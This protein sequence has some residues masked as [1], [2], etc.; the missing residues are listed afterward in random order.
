MKKN[1]IILINPS[2]GALG[3]HILDMPVSLLYL[4][5]GVVKAGYNTRVFDFRIDKNWREVL[6]REIDGETLLVGITVMAG[7]PIRNVVDISRFIKD[8]FDVPIVY[9]GAHPTIVPD[10]ILKEPY[11]DYIIRGFGSRALVE[12]AVELN[13]DRPDLPAVTGLAWIEKGVMRLNKN[14]DTFE[15]V[16]YRDIPYALFDKYFSRYIRI[17]ER[18]MVFPVYS[19]Y[20]CPYRCS[21][22]MAPQ[23][24]KELKN[25]WEPLDVEYVLE[26]MRYL[27]E[28]YGANNFYFYD[29]TALVDKRKTLAILK[30]VK[31]SGFNIKIG[32]RGMRIDELARLSAD[33]LAVL[34]EG[35]VEKI[36]V[37]VESGSPR[38]L[39]LLNKQITVEQI[40]AVNRR[41][42]ELPGIKPHYNFLG[43]IP[44]E[45]LE[46]LKMTKDLI[47][48]L[49]KDNPNCGIFPINKYQPYPG[50]VLYEEAIK[51]GF[52]PPDSFEG[53]I[54]LDD[55]GSDIYMP[56]Y[57]REYN[58]YIDMMKIASFFIDDKLLRTPSTSRRLKVLFRIASA[59]GKPIFNWRL[60]HDFSY[61]LFEYRI[62]K[63]TRTFVL[64]LK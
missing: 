8:R 19:S 37:G 20:G 10:I 38:M 63:Y 64:N 42:A 46:D 59:A 45:T 24:Y 56:W 43:G 9:G 52:V 2:F 61:L 47:L 25:R 62:Y 32:F 11:V 48:R 27:M 18:D 5:S 39:K 14:I 16:H 22:C 23:R 36:H 44:G 40:V 54:A 7:L 53:W 4:A 33:E 17:N 28:H 30:R 1:K 57:T 50:S 3:D 12:L 41:L 15:H 6:N 35:G 60:R 29:D 51:L 13:K 34:V 26:H 55:V 58:G 31:E 21:F 49:V